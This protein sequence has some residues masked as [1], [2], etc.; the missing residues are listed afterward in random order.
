MTPRFEI[1]EHTADVGL[2]LQGDSLEELFQAAGEGF[3]TLQGAWFPGVGE[4]REVEVR[5]VDNPGLLVAWI[6][7]LLYMQEAEDAVFGAFDVKRVA[8][9]ALQAVVR[10]SPRAERE[11]EAAGVKAATYHRLR[12]ERGSG[13]WTADVYLDV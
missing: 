2:Q 3:A 1:L 7:E 6:N 10:I 13:G 11:L 5:A 8:D 12:L 4:E 9:G